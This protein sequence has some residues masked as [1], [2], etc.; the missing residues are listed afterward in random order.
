M[1]TLQ[2]IGR[3]VL[4]YISPRAKE[5]SAYFEITRDISEAQFY[6]GN[7]FREIYLWQEVADR[8]MN[9]ERIENLLYG[10]FFHDDED[11][12]IETDRKF[13]ANKKS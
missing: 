13:M 9:V 2:S 3:K 1:A 5:Q 4:T 10:C 11:A 7:K 6:L 12:M 8:N